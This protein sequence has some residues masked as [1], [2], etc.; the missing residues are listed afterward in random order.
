M[1]AAEARAGHEVHLLCYAHGEGEAPVGVQVHRAPELLRNR[2]MRSGP[3]LE[4]LVADAGLALALARLRKHLRPDRLVAH[5]VEAALAAS[6][7]GR[8]VFFAHTDLG[9]ELPSYGPALLRAGLARAGSRVDAFL[10]KRAPG[11]AAVSPLLA[12]RLQRLRP[13]AAHAVQPVPVPWTA[14]PDAPPSTVARR[15]LELPHDAPV[16]LYAG[17]LDAYQG[18]QALT[19][20]LSRLRTRDAMLLVATESDARA[21]RDHAEQLGVGERLR[22]VGLKGEAQRARAHAAADLVLV[23]RA[24]P[25][26]LPIKLLDAMARGCACVTMRMATAELPLDDALAVC[27]D[28]AGSMAEAADRLLSDDGR[29]KALGE[30]ARRYVREE[31]DER[32]YLEAMD[33]VVTGS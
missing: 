4:K 27:D 31:H 11:V 29:R 24:A 13:D 28:D 22:V 8:F 25:G 6:G 10:L 33:R 5:H 23:P 15:E 14:P 20:A 19:L 26:G 21:L 3:S 12:R 1:L 16:L 7:P 30:A 32:R 9:A 2:S 17:N 18:W